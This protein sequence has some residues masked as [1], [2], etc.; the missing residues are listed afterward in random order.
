[1]P[2]PYLPLIAMAVFAIA[3]YRMGRMEH[4]WGA[5][6]AILSIALSLLMLLVL[7]W[8]WLGFFGGQLALFIGIT[9]YRMRQ[10]P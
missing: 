5:L 7:G 3:Y 2:L 8:G 6:W 1:M 4:S 9:F 10:K